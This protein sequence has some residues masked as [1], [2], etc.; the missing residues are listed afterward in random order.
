MGIFRRDHERDGQHDPAAARAQFWDWWAGEG[1]ALVAQALADRDPQRVVEPLS[2]AVQAID[3][4]L[5]WELG[6]G[7][8]AE[9]VLVVSPAGDPALRPSARRW[10][11]E[12][13]APDT[14]W[15]YADS[16]QPD[17]GVDQVVLEA[18]G[19]TIRFAD[20]RASARRSGH[21]LDVTIHHPAFPDLGEQAAHHLAALMLDSALGEADVELWVG[22]ISAATLPLLEGF[23]LSGLRAPVRDLRDDSTDDDDNPQWAMMQ[24]ET[25]EGAVM[26]IAQIP[27]SPLTAP[28]LD[29]H[30]AV[31]VPYADQ[32]EQGLPGPNSLPALRDLEEHVAQL[33]GASGRIVAHQ[34]HHGLRVLHLYADSTTPAVDQVRAAVSGWDQGE[35]VVS[36]TDD[37]T[38]ASVSYL[39]T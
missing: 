36:E 22:E 5:A 15:E 24:G 6:P 3:P 13:P 14:V 39:R 18:E 27:L 7:Q 17:P 30:I 34:S 9:H 20:A 10:L 11:R 26:A 23:P 29:L 19:T 35:V 2:A 4:G 12:A 31:L 38:W 25:A 37:P 28:D 32:T 1:S 16:R 8:V 21:H 33:L